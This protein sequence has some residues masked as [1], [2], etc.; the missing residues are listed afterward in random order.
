MPARVTAASF[1]IAGNFEDAAYCWRTQAGS[2]GRGG[3]GVVLA[4]VGMA[5]HVKAASG[6]ELKP[7]LDFLVTEQVP[8][9][10]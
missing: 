7:Y 2:W 5:D 6:D 10:V 3:E 1:A 9:H 4:R 8:I